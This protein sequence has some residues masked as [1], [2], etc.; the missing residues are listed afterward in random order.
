MK[1]HQWII[2]IICLFLMFFGKVLPPVMGLSE[3][4]MQVFC[5][6]VAIVVMWLTVSVSWPCVLCIVALMMTPLYTYSAA[7]QASMGFWV[8]SFVMFSSMITYVLKE[9]GFLRRVAI[10]FISRPFAKKNPW[11]FLGALFFACLF[12]GSFM[13]PVPDFIVFMPI[14]EQI[15]EELGYKKGDR[16]GELVT[17]SLLFFASLST[18]TT[19]IA[20][21]VPILGF[22]LY[23]QAFGVGIDFF[24]YTVFGTVTALVCLVVVLL[25]LKFI[26][27]LDVSRLKNL[28]T[29]KFQKSEPMSKKEKLTLIVFIGVVLMWLIPGLIKNIFPNAYKFINGLGT[30]TPALI[31]TV[32]L[33]MISVDGKPL[34]NIAETMKNGVSWTTIL[35]VA[36]TGILGNAMTNADAGITNAI[37]QTVEPLFGSMSPT[38]FVLLVSFITILITN[39]ASNTVTVTILCSIILPLVSEGGIMAGVDP[40][41]ITCVIGAGA[42]IACATP[43]S[44]ATAA[45]AGGTGWL[46]VSNMFKHGMAECIIAALALAFVGY[47]IAAAIM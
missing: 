43:P 27:K 7:L 34:M 32:I 38:I 24:G 16:F 10:W 8:V 14:T 11:L 17:L 42:A 4:G 36:A 28:D 9:T 35:M 31:G 19:P 1:K 47:P 40:A 15:F 26:A 20:H 3:V 23:E 25:Y 46:G 29:S 41:A 33:C 2:T 37:S 6:F 12:V 5:I 45:I 30:P 22:S 39:F 44:T 18:I 21:T 13:S